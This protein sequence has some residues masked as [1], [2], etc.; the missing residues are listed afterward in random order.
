MKRPILTLPKRQSNQAPTP[1]PVVPPK[2]PPPKGKKVRSAE[3]LASKRASRRRGR[4]RQRRKRAVALLGDIQTRWPMVFDQEAPKPLAI[5]VH[6]VIAEETGGDPYVVRTA[7]K[8][9]TQKKAYRQA[10]VAD[11]AMR[12]QPDGT[13][14][15][16]V[17]Q[18]DRERATRPPCPATASAAA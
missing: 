3:S 18:D 16:P 14:V 17:S 8:Y 4:S 5:G 15:G 12:Y 9:W 10:L 13:P 11:D 6:S 1:E 2:P 7:L